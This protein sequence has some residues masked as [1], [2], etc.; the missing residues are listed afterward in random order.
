MIADV[1]Y[2]LG[3]AEEWTESLR[4]LFYEGEEEED[5]TEL[6]EGQLEQIRVGIGVIGT[7]VASAILKLE[8]EPGA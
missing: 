1:L 7:Y 3:K 8:S 4:S 6:T 5:L 2:E